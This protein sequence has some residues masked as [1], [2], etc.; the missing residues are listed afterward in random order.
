M[1]KNEIFN[2]LREIFRDIFDDELLELEN[3][4]TLQI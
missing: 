4:L 3:N 2:E 1:T